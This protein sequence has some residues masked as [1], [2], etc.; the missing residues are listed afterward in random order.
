MRQFIMLT[1]L[2]PEQVV[3]QLDLSLLYKK[4]S[5]MI[6]YDPPCLT[7]GLSA[8]RV[9]GWVGRGEITEINL[10]SFWKQSH[11][12]TYSLTSSTAHLIMFFLHYS[13][14]WKMKAGW[15]SHLLTDAGRRFEISTKIKKGRG[16]VVWKASTLWLTVSW[17]WQGR[18][19]T[20]PFQV[21]FN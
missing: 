14:F 7:C 20:L 19:N 1:N 11:S 3:S 4:L 10:N 5:L 21:T 9:W 17:S 18:L 2:I 13:F 12:M 8:S 15:R 16:G 6:H